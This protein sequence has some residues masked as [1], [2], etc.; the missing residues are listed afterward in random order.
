MRSLVC[1]L[2]ALPLVAQAPF[3]P[4]RHAGLAAILVGARFDSGD[5]DGD[6]DIDLVIANDNSPNQLFLNDGRGRFTDATAGRLTTPMFNA[7]HDVELVDIDGDGDRDIL[8]GNDD[9]LSNRVYVNNGLGFFTDTTATALPPNFEF[10]EGQVVADF[11]GDGDVDWFTADSGVCH[12]YRNNGAGVFVDASATALGVLPTNLGQFKGFST[13]A[14]DVDA[15][16]DLD[17]VI[18]N[19]AGD[20]R[21]LLNQGGVLVFAPVQPVA[22]GY[23][24]RFADLDND[25]FPDLI[26]GS[27]LTILRNQGNGT[28]V[29][30]TAAAFAGAF[31]QTVIA[32]V[33]VDADGD[34]DLVT[35]LATFLNNGVG[36]FSQQIAGIS[37]WVF[38]SGYRLGAVAADFDGDGDIDLPGVPNFLRQ[39]AAPSPPVRGS[40]YTVEVHAPSGSL[41]GAFA[42]SGP[43]AQPLPPYGML[44]IDP[45]TAVCLGGQLLATN[46]WTLSWALP[47]VPQ[48]LGLPLHYQALVVDP[49]SGPRV[50]NAIGDVV[51]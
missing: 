46:P 32:C 42:A 12:F 48:I 16:G 27:G 50:S 18:P 41:V 35:H 14:A 30:V 26:A 24:H 36:V 47:N 21:L 5:V 2:F 1:L 43:A 9:F 33:D 34:L 17:L 49:I 19:S 31:H 51:Q 37:P 3:L 8:F 28:F 23:Y 13:D 22:T 7:S 15:D 11:D 40:T 45:A 4:T 10:T 39:I 20:L 29:D 38:P 6:G 25:G 44:R